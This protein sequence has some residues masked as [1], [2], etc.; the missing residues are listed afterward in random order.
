VHSL[1]RQ[2]FDEMSHRPASFAVPTT[3]TASASLAAGSAVHSPHGHRVDQIT[4]DA[5]SEVVPTWT[6]LPANGTFPS[7]SSVLHFSE[8]RPPPLYVPPRSIPEP[9]HHPPH[10]TLIRPPPITTFHQH[11]PLCTHHIPHLNTVIPIVPFL[12][13]DAYLN[14]LSPPS[15]ASIYADGVRSVKSTLPLT[16]STP[17]FGLDW[18]NTIWKAQQQSGTS[19][20]CHSYLRPPGRPSVSCCTIVLIVI[21]TSPC[22]AKFSISAKHLPCPLM[23]LPSLS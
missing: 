3:A 15:M 1:D 10:Q 11:R 9:T 13:L 17:P 5:G 14:F 8:P 22:S 12:R 19:P 20:S 2:V 7:P 21:S 6:H 18:L 23:S 16:L 4:R